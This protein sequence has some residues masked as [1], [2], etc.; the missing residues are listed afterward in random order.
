MRVPLLGKKVVGGVCP[1]HD[2][3]PFDRGRAVLGTPAGVLVLHRYSSETE[4]EGREL[5]PDEWRRLI[6]S[7]DAHEVRSPVDACP[8]GALWLFRDRFLD[9]E[10]AF[11]ELKEAGALASSWTREGVRLA[12]VD[13]ERARG[14]RRSLAD[15]AFDAAW[16]LARKKAWDEAERAA[17]Q[18]FVLSDMVPE[19][20]ALL[21]L[22]LEEKGEKGESD[23]YLGAAKN[24]L[25]PDELARLMEKR[26]Q[27]A[28][29][30]A[31]PVLAAPRASRPARLG[32]KQAAG[33]HVRAMKV[34]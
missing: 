24:S 12:L 34:A 1:L 22:V 5:D 23:G 10:L 7:G 18:A 26:R 33:N 16:G 4:A 19:H 27:Y 11:A 14:L 8:N 25:R 2:P 15:H 13:E 6:E 29:D 20:I 30:L 31:R 32:A 3:S 17:I 21:T 9:I 28:D